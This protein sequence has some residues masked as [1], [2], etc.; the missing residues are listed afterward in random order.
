MT[1]ELGRL[2]CG[3]AS[4]TVGSDGG[5]GL[6][7]VLGRLGLHTGEKKASQSRPLWGCL[8]GFGPWPLKGIGRLH[9]FQIFVWIAISFDFKSKFEIQMIP[10]R[11]IKYKSTHQ[12]KRKLMPR[13][14]MQQINIYLN[15]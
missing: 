10:I 7:L 11:G 8:L 5:A 2:W 15:N 13:H 9:H 14:E 12:Y 1:V 6:E 4:T 3:L